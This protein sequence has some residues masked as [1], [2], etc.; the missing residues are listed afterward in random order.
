MD[1]I[2]V[3]KPEL[4]NE[5][6][7]TPIN[8]R[9]IFGGVLENNS[10]WSNIKYT[11]AR[12]MFDMMRGN[13]WF[14]EHITL[15]N[16]KKDYATLPADVKNAYDMALAQI[17]FMDNFQERNLVTNLLPYVTVSSIAKL[18]TRQSWEECE[19]SNAYSVLT[20]TITDD[21]SSIYKKH[22]HNTLLQRKNQAIIDTF[23]KLD[24]TDEPTL[25]D[26]IEACFANLAL[27]GIY[28]YSAFALFWTLSRDGKMLGTS[29]MISYIARDEVT[30]T[31]LFKKIIKSMMKDYPE[32]FTP[33]YVKRYTKVLTDATEL[34][35]SWGKEIVNGSI[36]GLTPVMIDAY[37]EYLANDIV[38]YFK[39]PL[40]FKKLPHHP[41][42][43]VKET[44]K[45]NNIKTSMFEATPKN[46][47]KVGLL[48]DF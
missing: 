44:M 43:W 20:D 4:Y 17:V 19:H 24:I 48:D 45:F 8:E 37:I 35:K 10:D 23:N 46:Y 3:K 26:I 33:T 22:L 40:P 14:T 41:M 36:A 27:E 16:E 15:S 9:R 12:H 30:H 42:P 11:W 31:L 7:E 29:E 32:Y 39:F 28:F 1:E 13:T 21:S 5:T 2:L 18:L 34:E 47:N 38:S 6:I 25:P